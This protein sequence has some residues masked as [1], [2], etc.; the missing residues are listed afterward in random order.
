[1]YF[2]YCVYA[3]TFN[4]FIATSSISYSCKTVILLC[5]LE[6]IVLLSAFWE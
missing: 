4:V 1:M 5:V 3:Y 6:F 2:S